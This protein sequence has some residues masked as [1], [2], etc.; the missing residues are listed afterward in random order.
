MKTKTEPSPEKLEA[1]AKARA[2]KAAKK[3]EPSDDEVFELASKGVEGGDIITKLG[4]EDQL[5]SIAA[6]EE[7]SKKVKLGHAQYRVDLQLWL[8]RAAKQGKSN[9]VRGLAE[10]WLSRWQEPIPDMSFAEDYRKK[11]ESLLAKLH[12]EDHR[13][14][15]D[16]LKELK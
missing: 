1:L 3:D 11:I 15:K 10:A 2:A 4:L 16:N 14:C 5:S 9:A 8:T 7:F 6:K 13:H 12:D